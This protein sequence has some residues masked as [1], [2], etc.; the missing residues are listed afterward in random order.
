MKMQAMVMTS[1]GGP[2]ILHMCE[3]E[4]AWPGAANDVLVRLKAAGLNP[5][6]TFFRA[7]GAYL[8]SDGP[9]VLGHDGAGVVEAVGS[10]VSGFAVGDRVCFCNGGI[11]GPPGTYAEL[12]VVPDYQLA[13]IPDEVSFQTAAV[14]PLVAITAWEALVE[15]AGVA[16]GEHVLI[17]G[18]A[19]GTGQM[20]IQIAK[21]QG[22]KIAATV[23]SD[24][25][26]AL[27][28]S[29]GAERAINYR[30]D[31]F[32]DA[33]VK[34]TD[35]QGLA[36]ALDNAGPEVMARTFAAMAPYGHVVTL[37]GTPTDDA[38]LNAYN[39]NLTIH[40]VMM[41]T[42]MWF[43]LTEHLKRQGGIVRQ[44]VGHLASGEITMNI[45]AVYPLAEAAKAHGQ[46]EAGGMSG[47][48]V[49]DIA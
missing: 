39:R 41:L 32:V 24:A 44:L 29:L 15:R 9:T 46:M 2:D 40:N 12:A 42:P 35:G 6:D 25:K 16:G 19:G 14:F 5:A 47:K 13:R 49:L 23:S 10:D 36:V 18:G 28:K 31:D 11:G 33:A 48:I 37:M 20:A 27:V 17:H 3:V 38:D 7:S 43:G 26:A 22:A 8:E 4:V 34:W 45:A 30:T 1:P 21:L